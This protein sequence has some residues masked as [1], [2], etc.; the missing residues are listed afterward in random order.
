MSK[1]FTSLG[2]ADTPT[3]MLGDIKQIVYTTKGIW[4]FPYLRDKNT[5]ETILL[6]DY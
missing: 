2:L 5:H 1:K 3:S 6:Y 4:D